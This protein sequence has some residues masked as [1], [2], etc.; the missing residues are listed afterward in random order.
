MIRICWHRTANPTPCGAHWRTDPIHCL[1]HLI[2]GLEQSIEYWDERIDVRLEYELMGRD[3]LK[4]FKLVDVDCD[5]KPTVE[6]D[7]VCPN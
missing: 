6:D 3:D 7:V 4:H 1:M 2:K 5:A